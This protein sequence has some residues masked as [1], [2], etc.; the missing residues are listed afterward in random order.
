VRNYQR[1]PTQSISGYVPSSTTTANKQKEEQVIGRLAT[2]TKKKVS[3]K[4]MLELTSKNYE[5]LPEV[6]KRKEEQRKN[7]EK[8]EDMRRR[9][10]NAK[11]LDE[12]T[13]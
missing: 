13:P 3:K 5:Q 12:V 9:R 10:D 8:M 1:H 2:G 4:E 7:Q 6:V 11:K